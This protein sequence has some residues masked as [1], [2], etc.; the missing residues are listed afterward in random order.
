MTK[1]IEEL[2][3]KFAQDFFNRSV[4]DLRKYEPFLEESRIFAET[5]VKECMGICINIQE[6]HIQ[7][8]GDYLGNTYAVICRDAIKEYFEVE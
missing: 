4:V 7:E 1:R 6:N 2:V 8:F 5:I 3:E